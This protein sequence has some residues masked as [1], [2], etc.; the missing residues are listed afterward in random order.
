MVS[1]KLIYVYFKNID[2]LVGL[3]P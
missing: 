3:L 1:L 2:I